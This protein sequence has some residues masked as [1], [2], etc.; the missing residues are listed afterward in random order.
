MR[1]VYIAGVARYVSM[2]ASDILGFRQV[3]LNLNRQ[4]VIILKC[5]LKLCKLIDSS[6]WTHGRGILAETHTNT[7]TNQSMQRQIHQNSSESKRSACSALTGSA[8]A[9]VSP[10][11]ASDPSQSP[12]P[13]S[14][15]SAV[16]PVGRTSG[17]GHDLY[18]IPPPA[19]GVRDLVDSSGGGRSPVD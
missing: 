19:S 4:D 17:A 13:N 1:W 5:S 16:G 8:S 18:N 15:A 3:T 11:Q 14:R 2:K 9:E 10:V 7:N 12:S 6:C